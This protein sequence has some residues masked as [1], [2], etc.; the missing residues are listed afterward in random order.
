[1][2]S[3]PI[4]L[5]LQTLEKYCLYKITSRIGSNP[6]CYSKAGNVYDNFCDILRQASLSFTL[7]TRPRFRA[8]NDLVVSIKTENSKN[9]SFEVLSDYKDMI[10]LCKTI[11]VASTVLF[12]LESLA[13]AALLK[14]YGISHVAIF[15]PAIAISLIALST[16]TTLVFWIKAKSLS[17]TV[18]QIDP[19]KLELKTEDARKEYENARALEAFVKTTSSQKYNQFIP[20]E[21]LPN[22]PEEETPE[23]EIPDLNAFLETY[24]P[25]SHEL[26]GSFFQ[27][28]IENELT[29]IYTPH[30]MAQNHDPNNIRTLIKRIVALE[31]KLL[32]SE[33]QA[34][35][36][37]QTTTEMCDTWLQNGFIRISAQNEVS[38][39]S[40]PFSTE[41]DTIKEAYRKILALNYMLNKN[42]HLLINGGAC[43]NMVHEKDRCL[44]KILQEMDLA[45]NSSV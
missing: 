17:E 27:K 15:S 18:I 13:K 7:A 19:Q 21:G 34:F 8:L 45:R 29:R 40:F 44:L 26:E 25:L 16:I 1:M 43:I 10:T 4:T 20:K 12:S 3:T 5:R 33:N 11:F 30:N 36:S 6:A 42:L 35:P 32:P 41:L 2:S 14:Y 9:P 22:L 39:V 24:Q 23:K 31:N 28:S 38:F 37:E